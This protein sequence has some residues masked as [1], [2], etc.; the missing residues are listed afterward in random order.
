MKSKMYSKRKKW[1]G[2]DRLGQNVW[3]S[4]TY[5][6]VRPAVKTAPYNVVAWADPEPPKQVQTGSD[7][8]VSM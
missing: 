3:R 2:L 7:R 4:G 6:I 5:E 1:D 8:A